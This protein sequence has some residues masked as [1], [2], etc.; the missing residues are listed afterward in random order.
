MYFYEYYNILIN[1]V[2][3]KFSLIIKKSILVYSL[4]ALIIITIGFLSWY[5]KLCIFGFVI[6]F[7]GD[8]ARSKRF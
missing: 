8:F 4:F 5:I 2:K 6:N 7:A 1:A 3:N